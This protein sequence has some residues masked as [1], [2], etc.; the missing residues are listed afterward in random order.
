M[1]SLRSKVSQA[2]LG[3]F[4]LHDDQELYVEEM[5]K[6]LH[7]DK[8]NLVKKLREFVTEGLLRD[9]RRGREVYYTLNKEYHLFEEYRK[10]I[11]KT[12]G[13][14][15]Q[16][17]QLL[18]GLKGVDEAYIFG[19]YA[20]NTMDGKS[21]IDVLMVGE[22]KSVDVYARVHPLQKNVGREINIVNMSGSEY[23]RKLEKKDPFISEIVKSPKI[24]L[25]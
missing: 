6:K 1:L 7:V 12:Y 16:L 2:V 21:D 20:K 17:R 19:S 14:E 10:I 9:E 18:K 8:R 25:K 5:V 15:Q 13:V 3:Y 4:F 11:L 22:A 24:K 23:K